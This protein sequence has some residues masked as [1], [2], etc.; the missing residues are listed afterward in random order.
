MYHSIV[1]YSFLISLFITHQSYRFILNPYIYILVLSFTQN[2]STAS[3]VPYRAFRHF[4]Y[5]ILL[6]FSYMVVYFLYRYGSILTNNSAIVPSNFKCVITLLSSFF[7]KSQV[8]SDVATSLS[9]LASI[10]HENIMS[11]IY[12]V[13]DVVSSFL[14]QN[15]C[16]LPSAHPLSLIDPSLFSL[17]NFR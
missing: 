5:I 7:K 4:A 9:S 13:G 8:M 6:P 11:C 17:R 1:H 16:G 12:I 3:S 15:L 10:I 2:I 14:I